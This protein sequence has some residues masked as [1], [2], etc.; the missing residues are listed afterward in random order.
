MPKP[1]GGRVGGLR[2]SPA[3]P[4][5]PW[6]ARGDW[7][8]GTDWESDTAAEPVGAWIFVELA[9]QNL[10]AETGIPGVDRG[11]CWPSPGDR[12]SG[13][14]VVPREKSAPRDRRTPPEPEPNLA[15]HLVDLDDR[16]QRTAEYTLLSGGHVQAPSAALVADGVLHLGWDWGEWGGGL[17]LVHLSDL[18]TPM[19]PSLSRWASTNSV[20]G[21]GRLG[22]T[23]LAHGGLMHMGAVNA[24][25]V[26]PKEPFKSKYDASNWDN[27]RL[28]G[29]VLPI[30][31]L[32]EAPDGALTVL[33]Y[34]AIWRTDRT[35]AHWRK[36]ETLD[37]GYSSGRP[38][39]VGSYPAVTSAWLDSAG[40][41]FFA[42]RRDGLCVRASD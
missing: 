39:A 5:P 8:A 7:G 42:T 2:A 24:F 18:S 17:L 22:N 3:D 23:V 35:F 36:I 34:N 25:V 12:A 15:L 6:T 19:A 14:P 38:D 10:G 31:N 4:V 30:T 20:Y 41:L 21:F 40:R 11:E 32:L 29:P 9:E 26:E 16:T 13:H 1:A 37:L 27:P 28:P 33:A